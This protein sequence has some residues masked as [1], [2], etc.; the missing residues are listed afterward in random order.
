METLIVKVKDDS[1][2]E[3]VLELL[4]ELDYLEVSQ[5]SRLA[6]AGELAS[7]S[8]AEIGAMSPEQKAQLF[9]ESAGMWEGRDINAAEL[10]R[11]A[12]QRDH[13]RRS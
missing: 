4:Q 11:R 8:D 2:L 5:E 13:T 9:L 6:V 3:F 12:W 1:K 10:R 7:V